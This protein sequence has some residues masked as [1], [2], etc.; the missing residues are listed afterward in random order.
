MMNNHDHAVFARLLM[1]NKIS[2]ALVAGEGGGDF[3]VCTY[4]FTIYVPQIQMVFT[5]TDT[6]VELEYDFDGI[7]QYDYPDFVGIGYSFEEAWQNFC[8]KLDTMYIDD[9]IEKAINKI[10]RES[11]V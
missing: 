1:D 4:E 2:V 5:K 7:H 9:S 8:E 10:A 3:D 11:E 6:L